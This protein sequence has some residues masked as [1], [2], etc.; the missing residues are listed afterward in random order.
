MKQLTQYIQEKLHV[1]KYKEKEIRYLSNKDLPQEF[2]DN[3][4]VHDG[5]LNKFENDIKYR[6]DDK[7]PQDF[8]DKV[9]YKEQ[10]FSYWFK[11]VEV[12]WEEGYDA[13]RNEIIKRKYA[14]EDE[15]DSAGIEMYEI[16]DEKEKQNCLNYL[17]KYN[18]EIKK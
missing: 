14:T 8:I 1:S 15:I 11:A 16:H 4:T 2:W 12:G 5:D 9:K 7:T 17:K 6:N 10:L 18:I 3:F 13:F